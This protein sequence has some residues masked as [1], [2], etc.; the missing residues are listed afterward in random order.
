MITRLAPVPYEPEALCEQWERFLYQI[1]D[2]YHQP[3][4]ADNIVNFMQR[5]LGYALTGSTKEQCLFILW[6]GG[7]N[8]KSTLLNTVKK[9][10]GNY[11]LQTPT[12]TLLAKT[13]GGEIPADVARLDG[14]RLVTAS[15]VDRG[16]RL[17]ESLVKELTGRDTVS[18][19]F[20]YGEYFD[21]IPQ[22]KLFLSTNHKPHIR[23]TDNAI[24]RRIQMIPF[25]VQFSDEQQDKELPEKLQAEGPGILAWLVR[26]CLSW[27]QEGLGVPEEVKAATAEYRAEMDLLRDFLDSCCVI[28]PDLS[29]TADTLYKAYVSWAEDQGLTDKERLKQRGFGLAL[30]ERGFE[31]DR[32]THGRHLRHGIGLLSNQ[33]SPGERSG[34]LI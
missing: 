1:Q 5:S 18:A 28:G 8:G 22:F 17:G 24:W 14:P 29:A 7:A 23:G 4:E 15:E 32:T 9:L 3:A 11:A 31:R 34:D 30:T 33:G 20:L 27:Y 10:L 21:F 2:V 13:K 16:R 25:K 12:E 19:R 6:G 26:G